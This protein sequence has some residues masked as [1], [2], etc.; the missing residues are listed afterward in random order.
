MKKKFISL[1][2]IVC[3]AL[4]QIINVTYAVQTNNSDS[5]GLLLYQCGDF[6]KYHE[7][8][9]N[10]KDLQ[11]EIAQALEEKRDVI[12]VQTE[13]NE[14]DLSYI[15]EA[16]VNNSPQ[17]FY[18]D[19][20]VDIS[21]TDDGFIIY[22]K[23]KL[24]IQTAE[25]KTSK[26]NEEINKMLACIDSRMSALEKC[27]AIHEYMVTHYE[28]D[29][30]Y[31][32]YD[33]EGMLNNG[34][35]VCQAYSE[36]FKLMMDKLGIPCEIVLSESMDHAWNMVKINGYWYHIDVTWDDP[37]WGDESMD[38]FGDSRHEYFL[39]SDSEMLNRDHYDWE[40]PYKATSTKY[41]NEFWYTDVEYS[42]LSYKDG[43]WYWYG[44][45]FRNSIVDKN[46]PCVLKYSFADNKVS[47]ANKKDLSDYNYHSSYYLNKGYIYSK[48][49][50]KI[51]RTNISNN[52][53][54]VM[55]TK[56]DGN[57]IL[58]FYAD[59]DMLYVYEPPVGF[60]KNYGDVYSFEDELPQKFYDE[61]AQYIHKIPI[62]EMNLPNISIKTEA[63]ENGSVTI[64]ASCSDSDY[65]LYYNHCTENGENNSDILDC[66]GVEYTGPIT[67]EDLGMQY[68]EFYGVNSQNQYTKK[69]MVSNLSQSSSN[70]GEIITEGLSSTKDENGYNTNG[71]VI[72]NFDNEFYNK[73]VISENTY[74]SV[75]LVAYENGI[76]INTNTESYSSKWSAK[77]KVSFKISNL[78]SQ[79]DNITFKAF[80]WQN[81]YYSYKKTIMVPLTKSSEEIYK[82]EI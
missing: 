62:G 77:D 65:K 48:Y 30:T 43:Y 6:P 81:E 17:L 28:Y 80:V 23:Y 33:V 61:K 46:G 76:P 55:Y 8:V 27:L 4:S 37:L 70:A 44:K 31:S 56:T 36:T 68:I 29:R 24:Q 11:E 3:M 51:I 34:R 9:Y 39:V 5:Y 15:Y 19:N 25:T 7:F 14:E 82:I 53:F 10:Y 41:D 63:N 21:E 59:D 40:S 60:E 2:V 42:N 26:Y 54:N 18:I 72:L 79:T 58:G 35:G 74:Y 71:T 38:L 47:R 67:V 49:R 69:Q 64:S 73:I 32:I 12:N 16:A 22:P 78:K 1:F 52:D 13:L 50:D 57:E 75:I 45:Y 20:S 66:Q